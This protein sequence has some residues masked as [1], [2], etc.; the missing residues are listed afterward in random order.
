MAKGVIAAILV[1]FMALYFGR[2]QKMVFL[3]A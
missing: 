3:G 1:V 2:A